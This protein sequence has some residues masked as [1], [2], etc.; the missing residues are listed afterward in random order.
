ML[1][2]ERKKQMR[3]IGH[4][5]KPVILIGDNGMSTR[6]LEELDRALKDHELIKIKVRAERDA[7]KILIASL[8]NET[9]AHCVQSVGAIA[10]LFRAAERPNPRLSNLIRPI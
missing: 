7:R 4:H 6:L 5:L 9:G 8:C 3:A 1:T 2:P 10:L